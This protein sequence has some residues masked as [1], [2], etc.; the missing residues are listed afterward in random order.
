MPTFLGQKYAI[1]WLGR[2]PHM[3]LQ[4]LPVWQR[5]L[6]IYGEFVQSLYYDCFLGGPF[7]TPD[8]E[9]DPMYRMWAAN[10][11][12]RADAIAETEDE[13][14]IIEVSAYPGMRAVGQLFTYQALWLEDPLIPKIERLLLVCERLDND[15]GAA[16]GKMGIQCYVVPAEAA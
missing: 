7:L 6:E 16:A 10:T 12:K 4:D 9:K 15:I 3:L 2:P 1:D 11:A 13:I 8:Q 5:W 14:W